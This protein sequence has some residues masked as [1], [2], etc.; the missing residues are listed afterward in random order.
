MHRR[1]VVSVGLFATL[2]L[3]C[4]KVKSQ[5][6][7]EINWLS[8]EQLDDSLNVQPKKVFID[9]YT[10]WCIYCRKMDQVVFTKPEVVDLLEKEYYAVRMDAETTDTVY[11]EGKPFVNL[12]ASKKRNGLHQLAEL[13]A[14]RNGQ[15]APPTLIIL[16]SEFKVQRRYFEYMDSKK[17]LNAL[18]KK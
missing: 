12:Q 10:S 2:L 14:Q 13:L 4:Q 8:F 1:L 15:F 5:V 6:R 3:W 11:F 9:F 16:D 17:L 18:Q 7:K